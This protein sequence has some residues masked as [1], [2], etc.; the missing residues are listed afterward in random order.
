M[1]APSFAPE[2]NQALMTDVTIPMF[3]LQQRIEK[4]ESMVGSL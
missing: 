2:H 1:D 4:L 3:E